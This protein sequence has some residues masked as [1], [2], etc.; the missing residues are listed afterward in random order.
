[1][2]TLL[3]PWFIVFCSIWAVLYFARITHH[4]VL[5]L[6]GHLGDFLAVPVL[7]NL[8]LC[9]QRIFI[10]K[11]ST[12]VLKPGH[13]VFIVLYLSI[14]FEWLLPKYH[15]ETF[16]GDWT[17]TVLYV[18]GGVFFWLIINKPISAKSTNR[19]I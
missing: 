2:K 18:I 10:D 4:P 19:K 8:G 11:R 1:M 3:N 7:A 14:A 5:Y 16:T 17:D 6:N 12:Y 13:L 9:F 15:P